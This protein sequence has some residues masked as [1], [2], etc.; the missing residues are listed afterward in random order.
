M[1][2]HSYA[3]NEFSWIYILGPATNAQVLGVAKEARG[4]GFMQQQKM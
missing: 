4:T 3:F 1:I 2:Y